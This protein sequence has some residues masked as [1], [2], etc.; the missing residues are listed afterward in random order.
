M[1]VLSLP[2][3][4]A[5]VPVLYVV[6]VSVL[7]IPNLSV[8]Q[9]YQK[10]IMHFDQVSQYD[11]RYGSFICVHFIVSVAQHVCHEDGIASKM[12]AKAVKAS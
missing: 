10:Q 2:K 11:F 9:R 3:L 7:L 8:N 5:T 4:S 6:H 12:E 1:E